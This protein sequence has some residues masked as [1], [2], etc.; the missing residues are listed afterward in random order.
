MKIYCKRHPVGAYLMIPDGW[1]VHNY[2]PE[3]GFIP[4]EEIFGRPGEKLPCFVGTF[5]IPE[6]IEEM[7]VRL[8]NSFPL[9]PA[10]FWLVYYYD[11]D[12][13]CVLAAEENYFEGSDYDVVEVDLEE[14]DDDKI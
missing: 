5:D 7:C 10:N 4:T 1:K 12:N 9:I 3:K 2:H 14:V 6:T 11:Y 13:V 8:F